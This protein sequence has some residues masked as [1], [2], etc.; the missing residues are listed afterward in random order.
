M[1][2]RQLR[3]VIAI[4]EAGSV[5]KAAEQL[6]LVQPALSRQVRLLEQEL[7][8]QIFE[9][10]HSGMRLTDEGLILVQ[11]AKRALFALDQT[12]EEIKPRQTDVAGTV[13]V[14]LLPSTCDLVAGDLVNAVRSGFPRVRLRQRTGIAG[15]LQAWVATGEIDIALLYNPREH[16]ATEVIP[17]LDEPLFLVG[18]RGPE[19]EWGDYEPLETLAGLPLILPSGEHSV[20]DILQRACSVARIPLNVVAEADDIPLTKAL[21]TA[22]VGYSVLAGIAIAEDLLANRFVAVPMGS[23][24]LQRR[25]AVVRG[26]SVNAPLAV[27]HVTEVLVKKIKSVVRQNRWPGARLVDFEL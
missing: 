14:G 13:T 6:H 3:A 24:P 18:P 27:S 22:G 23:P 17:L 4:S 12:V 2:L 16:P 26:T 5:T 11:A 7:G 10:T 20:R 9:R 25:V 8:R 15:Q 1:E 21:L 19:A